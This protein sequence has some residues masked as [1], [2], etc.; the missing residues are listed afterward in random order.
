[1]KIDL[2]DYNN[3]WCELNIG[4][5]KSDIDKLIEY[6]SALKENAN[7]SKDDHFHIV[8]EKMN[9]Q[10]SGIVDIGF[11]IDYD[12]DVKNSNYGIYGQ[13]CFQAL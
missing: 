8:C 4:L 13:G 12:H 5:R 2:M 3:G 10:N 11:C 7:Q 6:L 1:M 9:R